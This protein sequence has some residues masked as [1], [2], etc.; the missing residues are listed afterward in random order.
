MAGDWASGH[1]MR[2]L[3]ADPET[4]ERH[5][6]CHNCDADGFMDS[7]GVTSGAAS[8][9]PCSNPKGN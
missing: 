3:P 6:N 1:D 9:Q 7:Q 2:E 8:Y 5:F 4:G